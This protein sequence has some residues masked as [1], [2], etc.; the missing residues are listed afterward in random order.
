MKSFST[1]ALFGALFMASSAFAGVQP[2]YGR[3][4]WFDFK[5]AEFASS[6]VSK[7]NPIVLTIKGKPN[8]DLLTGESK[9]EFSVRQ[10]S[11]RATWE[12]QLY[13][14]LDGTVQ[15]PFTKGD[16]T[17]INLRFFLPPDF[18][19][20]NSGSELQIMAKITRKAG[21]DYYTRVICV[22]GPIRIA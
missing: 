13:N 6:T 15:Q 10:G 19:N 22:R 3:E 11:L 20:V 2:C 21:P 17:D 8:A 12:S 4:K 9:V 18:K 5:R 14:A 1:L 16:S 7:T